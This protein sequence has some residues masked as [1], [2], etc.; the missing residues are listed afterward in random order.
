[1]SN[2]MSQTRLLEIKKYITNITLDIKYATKENFTHE[3]VYTNNAC[4]LVEEALQSLKKASEEFNALGYTLKIWDAY[5]PLRAQHIFWNLVPD[6]RY[7]A[8]PQKGSRHNRGCAIDLTLMDSNGHEVAM[9]TEFDDFSEKAHR[10][11]QDLPE[12]VLH[13]RQLLHTV[14]EKNNFIGWENEW[15]HFDFINWEQYPILDIAF[16]EVN[17]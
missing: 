8:N 16:E 5:R 4:Y 1:M 3:I 12:E 10:S 6:E 15:W 17:S 7:V 11:F 9:G 14:M 2:K 13:H